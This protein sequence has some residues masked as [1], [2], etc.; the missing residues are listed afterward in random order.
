MHRATNHAGFLRLI[1]D[2][3]GR[4]NSPTDSILP[5]LDPA[6]IH[7]CCEATPH[8]D[9]TEMRGQWLLKIRAHEEPMRMVMDNDHS[10][11]MAATVPVEVMAQAAAAE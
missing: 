1:E 4:N 9:G 6:G 3:R 5:I 11:F 8:R 7:L 2:S 10:V